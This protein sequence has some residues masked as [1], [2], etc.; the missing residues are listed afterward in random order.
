M[1]HIKYYELANK[2]LAQLQKGAFLTVKDDDGLINTMTIGW[3][4][5][6][7]MWMR[8]VFM[9]M[10]RKSRYTY[11]L[12][13][14]T[15]MFTV[16]VPLSGQLKKELTACGTTSGRD[17]NKF[18]DYKIKNQ[19]VLD[20]PVPVISDCDLHFLC[21]IVYRQ[22]MDTAGI[23]ETVDAVYGT[24]K[25]YHTLYYGE[26]VHTLARRSGS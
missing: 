11:Q 6:G 19:Y 17:V 18:E 15:K 1:E 4:T 23:E 9:V 14:N 26:I 20:F 7:Y 2:T 3:G 8:P 21:N 12:I 10:V 5:L 16:S 22:H 13:E 25:D 24:E